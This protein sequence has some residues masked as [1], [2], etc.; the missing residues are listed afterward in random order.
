[1]YVGPQVDAVK[2]FDVSFEGI[3]VTVNVLNDTVYDFNLSQQ[4][5]LKRFKKELQINNEHILIDNTTFHNGMYQ[6]KIEIYI[7]SHVFERTRKQEYTFAT[8]SRTYDYLSA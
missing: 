7:K 6:R 8:N 5:I 3:T 1:M 2:D 4:A